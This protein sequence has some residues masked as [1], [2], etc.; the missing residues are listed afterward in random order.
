MKLD[1]ILESMDQTVPSTDDPLMRKLLSLAQ[2]IR[3]TQT[4]GTSWDNVVAIM[5]KPQFT[6]ESKQSVVRFF[7]P[8]MMDLFWNTLGDIESQYGDVVDI[9]DDENVRSVFELVQATRRFFRLSPNQTI[10]R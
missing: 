1:Q 5:T 10:Q 3:N 6:D 9:I 7:D 4:L 8:K 2:R